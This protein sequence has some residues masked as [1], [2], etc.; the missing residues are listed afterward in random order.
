MKIYV[1]H[2]KNSQ[3]SIDY[4]IILYVKK[5]S[6]RAKRTGLSQICK[7]V[8]AV[9]FEMFRCVFTHSVREET[10][11]VKKLQERNDNENKTQNNEQQLF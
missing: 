11:E 8:R 5:D 2:L 7:H 10:K 1:P 3:F 4:L 6:F 9:W